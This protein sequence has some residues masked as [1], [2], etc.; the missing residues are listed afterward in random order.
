MT[1]QVNDGTEA[2]QAFATLLKTY[3]PHDGTFPLAIP[4][5]R[6]CRS[7]TAD[8]KPTNILSQARLCIVAQGAKRVILGDEA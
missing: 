3:A 6:I 4:G 5:V 2:N 7:S 8:R 1:E